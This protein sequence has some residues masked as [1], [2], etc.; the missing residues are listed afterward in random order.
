MTAGITASPEHTGRIPKSVNGQH[1][2]DDP[3][4]VEVITHQ[5]EHFR[6]I[7]P[8]CR[9]MELPDGIMLRHTRSP[10]LYFC[11][12]T[13]VEDGKL[14]TQVFASDSPYDLEKTSIGS[15][16]SAM[17]EHGSDCAHLGKLEALIRQWV[18]FVQDEPDT[19]RD[20]RSFQV[21]V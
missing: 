12:R 21:A 8:P 15:V 16:V 4:V 6:H 2:D 9:G 7:E 20:F 13:R 1:A 10:S 11:L 19:R 14:K 5:L 3:V 18:E 17:F